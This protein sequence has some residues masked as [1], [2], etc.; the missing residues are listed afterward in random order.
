LAPG[1]ARPLSPRADEEVAQP[2]LARAN[3]DERERRAIEVLDVVD[4]IDAADETG[5][6]V[7]D[8]VAA[9]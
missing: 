3:F 7:G 2:R 6:R 8:D 9:W 5:S 4:V 1:V